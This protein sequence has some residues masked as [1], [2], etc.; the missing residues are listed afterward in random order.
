MG[1]T[2]FQYGRYDFLVWDIIMGGTNEKN[3]ELVQKNI[4]C[5]FHL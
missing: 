1:G 3:F 5:F 4:F 2:I